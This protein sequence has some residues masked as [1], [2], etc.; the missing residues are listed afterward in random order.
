LSTCAWAAKARPA[1]HSAVA[2]L[3]SICIVVS[4]GPAL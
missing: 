2:N 3:L 4:A 1:R